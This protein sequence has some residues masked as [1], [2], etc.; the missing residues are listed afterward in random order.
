MVRGYSAIANY[1]KALEFAQKAQPQAP[2]ARIK[3]I[4][5]E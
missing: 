5:K 3:R 2:D 4:L 1:K